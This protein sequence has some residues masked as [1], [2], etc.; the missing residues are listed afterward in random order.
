MTS[1]RALQAKKLGATTPDPNLNLVAVTL[2]MQLTSGAA[3][4]V[5]V[6]NLPLE[7]SESAARSTLPSDSHIATLSLVRNSATGASTGCAVMETTTPGGIDEILKRL[8]KTVVA[9]RM[10]VARRAALAPDAEAILQEMVQLHQERLVR[11]E[12][13]SSAAAL[14]RCRY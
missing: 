6:E 2:V 9:G 14:V 8:N 1:A 11:G 7:L 3:Q 5:Y 10:L 12:P 4:K 13:L